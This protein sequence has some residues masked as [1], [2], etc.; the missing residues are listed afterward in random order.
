[1]KSPPR[2]DIDTSGAAAGLLDELSV[3]V[4]AGRLAALLKGEGLN[5][6]TIEE[7]LR[8]ESLS[9]LKA[10]LNDHL[11]PESEHGTRKDR[12]N[13]GFDNPG[14]GSAAGSGHGGDARPRRTNGRAA[15]LGL[16]FG[17]EER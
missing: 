11:C 7:L 1:M 15:R 5:R 2:D 10:I 4:R 16:L 17:T 3:A 9:A 13:P 12:R 8:P 14:N 6:S